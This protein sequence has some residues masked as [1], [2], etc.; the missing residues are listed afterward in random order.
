M[1]SPRPLGRSF[2]NAVQESGPRVGVEESKEENE[3]G[4]EETIAR[5]G[6]IDV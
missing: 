6:L 5:E 3:E 1:S 2:S 4:E